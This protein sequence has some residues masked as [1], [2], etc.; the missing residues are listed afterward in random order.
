MD[1]SFFLRQS[2]IG[3]TIGFITA[4]S[5]LTTVT[6]Q[7][8]VAT[9]KPVAVPLA[10]P[11][12]YAT[13]TVNYIRTWEPVVSTSDT[14]YVTM[15]T[16]T[17]D[18][19]RQMTQYFDGLGR[20]IQV[21][22]KAAS[23]SGRD[24][25]TPIV[26]D[27]FG[28][29]QAKYLPYTASTGDGRFKT[30]PFNEQKS[31]YQS[32]MPGEQVYYNR[33]DY[34]A[35]PLNRTLKIYGPGASWAKNDPSGVERGGNKPIESRY[36]ANTTADS[37]R[38][39]YLAGGQIIPVSGT[40]QIYQAGELSKHIT[41]DEAGNQQV[42]YKDKEGR[43]VM[44]K[45]QVTT[46]PG[47]AHMGWLCTYYVYDQ[48]GNLRFVIP[49]KVTEM[50]INGNWTITPEIAN[51]LCFIYRYDNRSRMIVKK[52]P[53]ADST[54]MVYDLRD[55]LVFSRDGKMKGK[56]WIATFYDNLNR[57]LLVA[58]YKN[59]NASRETLQTAVNNSDKNTQ[60][61]SYNFPASAN[62]ILDTFDGKSLYQAT[63]SIDL[64]DGFETLAGTETQFEINAGAVSGSTI[65]AASYSL[66][67]IS[68]DSLM[69]MV[70]SYYDSY[71]FSGVQAYEMKD[72]SRPQSDGSP[73]AQ[74]LPVTGSNNTKGLTTGTK[75]RIL[76]TDRWLTTTLY[77]DNKHR[78][79]QTLAENIS[80]GL[81]VVTTMYDFSGKVISTYHRQKNLLSRI[82]P[83]T[84]ILTMLAYDAGGRLIR[85]KK[86]LNDTTAAG[87]KIVAINTYNEMGELRTK[88]LGVIGN[89]Q[90]ETLTYD[91]NVRGWL[92]G[93]NKSFVSTSGNTDN[94]FGQTL[95]YDSG[96]TNVTYN[97]NIA[98]SVWKSRS[99]GIARAYGF[100]YDKL[101]RLIAASFTQQNS[102]SNA[103]TND[104]KDFSV[105][106]LTFDANGNILSMDQKGMI[107]AT[108]GNIDRLV[109]NYRPGANKLKSVSDT[110]NSASAKLG[111]FVD[112]V[113][114][115]DDYDYDVDGNLIKDLNK[116]ITSVVYNYLN[117][118]DSIVVAGK[119]RIKFLYDA[120]GRKL[121][122]IVTDNTNSLPRVIVTD[123][124]GGSVYQND[125]LQFLMHEEGRIR[126]LMKGNQP[127]QYVYDYFLRD[128]LGNVRTVLTDQTD[129]TIYA[130]S[131]ETDAAA[132]ETATFSNIDATRVDR[133]VGY[134]DDRSAG[135]N[136][137]VAKLTAVGPG[138]KVGPSIVL[139]VM[140]GDT[141]QISAKAFYKSGG[142]VNNNK[143]ESNAENILAD[144]VHAFNGQG[145]TDN[146]IHNAGDVSNFTPFSSNFYNNDYR[147]L[148][149]KE[150]PN[151]EKSTEQ[152]PKAYLNFVMFDEDFKM[153]EENSGVRQL[154][155]EPDQLQSL[156]QGEM[157]IKKTG[158]I[159][160]YT[161]NESPQ[162][163]YF[164][165]VTVGL[166]SGPLLEEAHYYP[167]G[168]VMAGISYN[169]LRG[170]NYPENKFKYNGKE[171]QNK[172]F[173][174]G[175]GLEWHDYGAR[176][177]DHQL[178]RWHSVDQLTD[179]HPNWT[180][181]N[182]VVNNPMLLV[183]PDG[184][185]WRITMT[186]DKNGD[187]HYGITFTGVI[188][189]SSGKKYDVKRFESTIKKQIEYVFNVKT[190]DDDGKTVTSNID[191]NLKTVS[192]LEEISNTDHIIDIIDPESDNSPMGNAKEATGRS[193]FGGLRSYIN[194]NNLNKIMSGEDPNTVPHE[195]GH[196]AG[197]IHPNEYNETSRWSAS[198]QYLNTTVNPDNKYNLMWPFF[199]LDRWHIFHK[200]ALSLSAT[201]LRLMYSN[202]IDGK[203][204]RQRNFKTN[205]YFIPMSLPGPIPWINIIKTRGGLKYNPE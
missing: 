9:T 96:F 204:N 42:E 176:M 25:I 83:Q 181:Y 102:G 4:F 174:D 131:M 108:P 75:V 200:D 145:Y 15:M 130:A 49:P 11:G 21:V 114:G 149:E 87:D 31:F 46:T 45:G 52:V 157:I 19:V 40:G 17:P 27:A 26:Y 129:F 107:G 153:V 51:E 48:L 57:P 191:V 187:T 10:P 162:D 112:G 141:I 89:S 109:Y 110:C 115:G 35:S 179:K 158:F 58:Q 97:G 142:P 34:E 159:Y 135:P 38:A 189:N 106:N 182:Y 128:H 6:A 195:L 94:W 68:G 175:S 133:P 92:V 140:A 33:V 69:P 184:R 156:G 16:R 147:R 23:I 132:R 56:Y 32:V 127:A 123:Y 205:L 63:S 120:T 13:S 116:N 62:L 5:A 126:P 71:T 2:F 65:I 202:Y 151:V 24:V 86:R 73:N 8:P 59:Y 37:V 161:S 144:L 139:R 118:P 154:R 70:Y 93:I 196:T 77:Y 185:D 1:K 201:Q 39:W 121:R 50:A 47:S 99:D 119:G 78:P 146:G 180:P 138:R 170:T 152:R 199:A 53:G 169:S 67:G 82:N 60:N 3:Y 194:Y 98:G 80:G 7:T 85:I 74:P 43:V 148:K 104:Q 90:L 72:I 192:A 190:F 101:N 203:L 30:D 155:A 134:P 28:R 186:K 88:R 36:H 54:E 91:Y 81:D 29:E 136:K 183:D 20:P 124:I 64:V 122:K 22:S 95:A 178:G 103:W 125:T 105:S 164:D 117:L 137:S 61:I 18:Q 143:A 171:L 12:P 111:D 14:A 166:N 66:P 168:L 173:S 41:I 44:Q 84:S 188:Y 198:Q 172:E 163:V 113:N 55:R 100:N 160:A 150:N 76:G 197:L 177:Y 79:I 167:F 193:P 165:N